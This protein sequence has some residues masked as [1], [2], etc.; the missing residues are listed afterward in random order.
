MPTNPTVVFAGPRQV[1]VEDRPIAQ[2]GPGEVLIRTHCSL[3]SIGTE[4]SI[5]EGDTPT[6]EVWQRL[7]RYP[8]LPGYDNVGTVVEVGEGVEQDWLGRRVA[9]WGRHG[10]YVTVGVERCWPV[11]RDVSDAESTFLVLG[12]IAL[13]GLRR[14]GLCFGE[15]AAVYGLGIIGQLTVQLCRFAGARPVFGIDAS[16]DRVARLAQATGV[17]GICTAEEDP[18]E[19]I[20]DATRGRMADVVF[21]L[22]GN[23]EI[24]PD[25]VAVLRGQGRFVIVSSPRSPTQFDFH[26][27]CNAPSLTIIGAHNSSH[28]AHATP[29]DPWT[30]S[31]H[32]ELFFDLV[33]DGELA[34]RPLISDRADV[35]D[36]PEVYERL[37]ADRTQTMGVILRWTEPPGHRA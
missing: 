21:E 1:V 15:S 5:L 25:E 11:T 34:V 2:P 32:A 3:I 36:A 7:R 13:N 30:M 9:S 17:T 31:R 29:A 27:L 23:G 28:P 33:A 18:A 8:A 14:S 6:G 12:Q 24:L 10:G 16:R 20:V 26:D 22:T 4:L 35:A 19:Q 37:M